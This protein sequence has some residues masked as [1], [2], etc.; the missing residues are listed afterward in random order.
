M[1]AEDPC[2]QISRAVGQALCAGGHCSGRSLFGERQLATK[3]GLIRQLQ[4]AMQ[5]VQVNSYSNMSHVMKMRTS[6]PQE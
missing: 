3:L 5:E 1:Q 6:R 4:H 2:L